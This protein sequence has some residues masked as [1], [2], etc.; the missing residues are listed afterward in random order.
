MKM[1]FNYRFI[2]GL[3]FLMLSVGIVYLPISC[4][5]NSCSGKTGDVI[6]FPNSRTLRLLNREQAVEI[7]TVD[8]TDH[9]FDQV[10]ALDMSLQ[11]RRAYPP[12]TSRQAIL[13][14]YFNLL[15]SDV[16]DFTPKEKTL[17]AE[18]FGAAFDACNSLGSNLL[19]KEINIVKSK[20]LPYG[21]GVFYT[22]DNTIVIPSNELK[23][24]NKAELIKTMLHELGHIYTRTHVAKKAALYAVLGFKKLENT[25]LLM[26]DSLYQRLL[27]NPDG[28]NFTWVTA[29]TMADG[30][31]VMAIPLI[32]SNEYQFTSKKKSYMDYLSWN[33]FEARNTVR[34]VELLTNNRL[35]T[36]LQTKDL[37]GLFKEKL[38]TDYVIHPDE[39][40]ADNFALLT[41]SCGRTDSIP[42]ISAQGKSALDQLEIIIKN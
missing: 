31:N 17:T 24:A 21:D 13:S 9:Y 2:R 5:F 18:V 7:I 27:L 33:Y 8:Q 20:G 3:A 39:I 30:K 36:T 32:Y 28:V 16:A 19:P 37:P 22:R 6:D 4:A 29:L 42:A 38:N 11:L 23:T 15:K 12:E 25:H 26:N 40:F 41:G 14:D 1:K 34:G 35:Q 10:S